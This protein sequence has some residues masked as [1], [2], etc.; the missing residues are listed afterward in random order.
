MQDLLNFLK[1]QSRKRARA[2]EDNEDSKK[3]VRRDSSSS[4]DSN[5]APATAP[6]V[7]MP[8]SF[9]I[10]TDVPP[11]QIQVPASTPLVTDRKRSSEAITE[12]SSP[13]KT[14]TPKRR[15]IDV[16]EGSLSSSQRETH[17][18]PAGSAAMT[19]RQK[20]ARGGS[21]ETPAT[22]KW[23]LE[24]FPEGTPQLSAEKEKTSSAE[25]KMQKEEVQTHFG[26][27]EKGTLGKGKSGTVLDAGT[28][29]D[30]TA[31]KKI[32]DQE[33]EGS[34]SKK[35]T[36]LR[37]PG[38]EYQSPLRLLP[39]ILPSLEDVEMDKGKEKNRLSRMLRAFQ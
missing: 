6:P 20:L 1:A 25:T 10:R 17:K 32:D 26:Q 35:V 18:R 37:K 13:I 23:Q 30:V 19:Q 15:R 16:I 12:A 38:E 7:S 21:S 34:T 29:K 8:A 36:R 28:P 9:P 5:D 33:K 39:L 11:P 2:T 31:A 24:E 4:C 14:A 22:G 3:R 27:S